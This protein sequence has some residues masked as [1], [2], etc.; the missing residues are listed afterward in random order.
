MYAGK[1]EAQPGG[2]TCKLVTNTHCYWPTKSIVV[3]TH[4]AHVWE[5]LYPHSAFIDPVCNSVVSVLVDTG[6]SRTGLIQQ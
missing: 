6:K 4:S 5:W 2:H 1:S 3:Q